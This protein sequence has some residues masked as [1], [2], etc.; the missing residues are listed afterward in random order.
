MAPS[1]A[2]LP[3]SRPVSRRRQPPRQRGLNELPLPPR[4]GVPCHRHGHLPDPQPISRSRPRPRH[5]AALPPSRPVSRRRQPPGQRGQHQ[6]PLAPDK[7]VPPHRG[8]HLPD[9]QPRRR[10][11]PRPRHLAALPASRPVSRRRQP[12]GQ[13]RE[14]Q[15][16]LPSRQAVPSN[17]HGHL[18]DPQPRRGGR[19]RPRHRATM[20]PT[21]ARADTH[22]HASAS[23][24]A[25]AAGLLRRVRFLRP[26]SG[27]ALDPGHGDRRQQ[28]RLRGGGP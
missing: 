7:A 24:G 28:A 10:G 3:P 25:G 17:R 8:R 2:V 15:L 23:W 13:R 6:L 1:C 26:F 18:P 22:G 4:Q 27:L 21:H 16:P 19:P 12:P 9:P 20:P 11:R 5:L 14:H